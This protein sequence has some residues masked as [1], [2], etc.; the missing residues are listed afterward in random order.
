[1]YYIVY[2]YIIVYITIMEDNLIA[3]MILYVII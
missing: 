2:I 3:K 1:M